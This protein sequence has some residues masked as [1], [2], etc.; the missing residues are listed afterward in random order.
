MSYCDPFESN[1]VETFQELQEA[2][3]SFEEARFNLV[4]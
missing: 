1:L 4:I 2:R 3:A